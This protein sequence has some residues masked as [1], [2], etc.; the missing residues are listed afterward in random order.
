MAITDH[1]FRG[2]LKTHQA[3]YER[4]DGRIGENLFGTKALL[5]RTKGRKSGQVRTAALTF[6][7]DG[8]RY[9]IVA[10]KGGAPEPPAWFLNLRADPHPEIQVGRER[11]AATATIIESGDPDYERVWKLVNDGNSQRYEAYQRK[12]S[13]P[14]PVVAL[15]RSD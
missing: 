14:I 1:I 4:T 10:S 8:D 13:R 5:L 6:A 11:S 3:L 2:V 15:T 12:T 7:K 9:L